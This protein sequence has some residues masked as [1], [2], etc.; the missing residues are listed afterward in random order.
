MGVKIRERKGK[1]WIFVDYRGNRAAKCA[2]GRETAIAAKEFIE[3]QIAF[4][5]YQPPKREPPKPK[6]PPP[7]TVKEYYETFK[8]IYLDS[9]CR[10]S[11][12]QR[13]K[14][15]FDLYI[16]PKFGSEGLSAVTRAGVK[17]FS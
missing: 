9:A 11:T 4:G 5:Q 16:L 10:E 2:G 12:R 7:V 14:D 6:E 8:R 3:K 1:W 13:Y 17:D 15:A